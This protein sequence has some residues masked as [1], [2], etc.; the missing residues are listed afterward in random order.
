MKT[1]TITLIFIALLTHSCNA[2]DHSKDYTFAVPSVNKDTL[3]VL[4][5]EMGDIVIDIW[6]T[7]PLC[8]GFFKTPVIKNVDDIAPHRQRY[9]VSLVDLP[10]IQ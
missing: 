7:Q 5:N 2:Q 4:N 9:I 8:C 3:Y 1:L 10:G 6:Q